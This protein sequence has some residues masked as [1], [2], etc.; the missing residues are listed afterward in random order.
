M[1]L[2]ALCGPSVLRSLPVAREVRGLVV[3]TAVVMAAVGNKQEEEIAVH[4]S[5]QCSDA[6][7]ATIDR[8]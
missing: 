8:M 7:M 4:P 2:D 1:E 3:M 5:I 6:A